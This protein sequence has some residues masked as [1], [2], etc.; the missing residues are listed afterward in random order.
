MQNGAGS[1]RRRFSLAW[2]RAPHSSFKGIHPERRPAPVHIP[3]SKLP[4]GAP[5]RGAEDTLLNSMGA[6]CMA[7]V[8][9]MKR[10]R[11]RRRQETTVS[12]EEAGHA[13][14]F[15]LGDNDVATATRRRPWP[16]LTSTTTSPASPPLKSSATG[17]RTI[18]THGD[19]PDPY[20]TLNTTHSFALKL[21]RRGGDDSLRRGVRGDVPATRRT[22][23]ILRR[24][25]RSSPPAKK[26]P[27]PASYSNLRQTRN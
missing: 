22:R 3:C 14:F 17:R 15:S 7:V 21:E 5:E 4:S 26:E 6:G 18:F 12:D 9:G 16:T 10:R 11:R 19:H 13:C 8:V 25:P 27:R 24:L 2:R 20:C 23:R 1:F